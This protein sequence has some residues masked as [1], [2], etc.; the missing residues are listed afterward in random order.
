MLRCDW[1]RVAFTCSLPRITRLLFVYTFITFIRLI[2]RTRLPL[3]RCARSTLHVYY[4]FTL[5]LLRSYHVYVGWFGCVC[6]YVWVYVYVVRWFTLFVYFTVWLPV[7]PHAHVYVAFVDSPPYAF[8]FPFTFA[9]RFY[10]L[11]ALVYSLPAV[12]HLDYT[13]SCY[14]WLL[15][16]SF[17]L[18]C[19]TFALLRLIWLD[20]CLRYV[21]ITAFVCVVVYTPGWLPVYVLRL[22]VAVAHVYTFTGLYGYVCGCPY[23]WL[24]FYWLLAFYRFPVVTL[25][26]TFIYVL[27]VGYV[28]VYVLTHTCGYVYGLLPHTV[29]V[30]VLR[31]HLHVYTILLHT[32]CS[33]R[34]SA[35]VADCCYILCGYARLLFTFR[36]RWLLHL[37]HV[38]T[39]FTTL[40]PRVTGYHTV[41]HAAF[42]AAFYYTVTFLYVASF[43]RLRSFTHTAFYVCAVRL[44]LRV[45]FGYVCGSVTVALR[46]PWFGFAFGLVVHGL[47]SRLPLVTAR[48]VYVYVYGAFAF[49]LVYALPAFGF[50][51]WLR[52]FTFTRL[53]TFAVVVTDVA[54]RLRLLRFTPTRF[55]SWFDPTTAI[56]S[57]FTPVTFTADSLILPVHITPFQ[58]FWICDL[59][60]LP[61]ITFTVWTFP[62]VHV[63]RCL[64]FVCLLRL[65]LRVDRGCYVGWLRSLVAVTTF[66]FT[67]TFVTFITHGYRCVYVW[68]DSVTH[69]AFLRLRFVTFYLF[70]FTFVVTACYTF[71]VG[72][73]LFAFVYRVTPRCYW[74]Y[75]VLTFVTHAIC[76][77]PLLRLRHTLHRCTVGLRLISPHTVYVTVCCCRSFY[78]LHVAVDL[79]HVCDSVGYVC[80][81]RFVTYTFVYV[82]TFTDSRWILR[83]SLRLR[84]P[85]I[86]LILHYVIRYVTPLRLLRSLLLFTISRF[87]FAVTHHPHAFTFVT[88]RSR[89][90]L[91]L[92]IDLH[93]AVTF[94]FTDSTFLRLLLI[95]LPVVTFDLVLR[96]FT[97]RICCLLRCLRTFVVVTFRCVY[98]APFFVLHF[99]FT[100]LP[101]YDFTVRLRLLLLLRYVVYALRWLFVVDFTCR[102]LRCCLLRCVPARYVV[103]VCILR[104]R[105]VYTLV[106]LRYTIA[107]VTLLTDALRCCRSRLHRCVT[108]LILL[109]LGSCIRSVDLRFRSVVCL[110]STFTRHVYVWISLRYVPLRLP[111]TRYGYPLFYGFHALLPVLRFGF[112]THHVHVL[113]LVTR[114]LH[115]FVDSGLLRCHGLLPRLRCPFHFALH[116]V[117]TTFAFTRLLRLP[118]FVWLRLHTLPR[119]R[120]YVCL[121]VWLN[122]LLRLFHVLIP[123]RLPVAR[124]LRSRSFTLLHTFT[125]IAARLLRYPLRPLRLPTFTDFTLFT[126]SLL[127]LHAF[128][129]LHFT[130]TVYWF[131]FD[132]RLRFAV[133]IRSHYPFYTFGFVVYVVDFV[134]V[135]RFRTR[136]VT[137]VVVTFTLTVGD[138]TLRTHALRWFVVRYVRVVVTLPG[139]YVCVAFTF[140]VCYVAVWHVYVTLPR[141]VTLRLHVYYVW[142]FVRSRT[143]TLRYVCTTTFDVYVLH[144]LRLR[145]IC[146][147]RLI[148]RYVTL[149][150]LFD[151]V[152]HRL[153]W[154]FSRL[155]VYVV[156]DFVLLFT[157]PFVPVYVHT[158]TLFLRLFV[159]PD[160][161][162]VA[163]HYTHYT[164]T[165]YVRYTVTDLRSHVWFVYGL[166]VCYVVVVCSVIRYVCYGRC[167]TRSFVCSPFPFTLLRYVG[168]RYTF[169]SHVL[170]LPVTRCTT[171]TFG[172]THHTTFHV[173]GA[174]TRLIYRSRLRSTPPRCLDTLRFTRVYLVV[175]YYVYTCYVVYGYV[176]L[177]LL[178]PLRYVTFTLPRYVTILRYV[179]LPLPVV[180]LRYVT[181]GPFVRL[182]RLFTRLRLVILRYILH[183]LRFVTR[184][185]DL[186]LQ[187]CTLPARLFTT[188]PFTIFVC[189]L[190]LFHVVTR[191][192]VWFTRLRITLP[193]T[194]YTPHVVAFPRFHTRLRLRCHVRWLI[195]LLFRIWFRLRYT[196]AIYPALVGCPV[197]AFTTHYCVHV[198]RCSR[199]FTFGYARSFY[200]FV[201]TTF[202]FTFTWFCRGYYVLRLRFT[203]TFTFTFTV[204]RLRLHTVVFLRLRLRTFVRL[205][206]YRLLRLRLRC[207]AFSCVVR[208]PRCLTHVYGY[209]YCT[210]AVLRSRLPLV[211]HTVCSFTLVPPVVGSGLVGLRCVYTTHARSLPA[212]RLLRF[213][214]PHTFTLPTQLLR[215]CLFITHLPARSFVY[216]YAT[217]T[218]DFAVYVLRLD[219]LRIGSTVARLRTHTAVLRYTDVLDCARLRLHGL[220]T[221]TVTGLVAVLTFTT[222]AVWLRVAF[223]LFAH[224]LHVLRTVYYV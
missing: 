7:C 93:V 75:V 36:S 145:L 168:L 44:I 126:R 208:T 213:N 90:R 114:L 115:R 84:V 24:T 35:A 88:L 221:V 37:I 33:L 63:V 118:R 80:V 122:L 67:F 205:T 224:V 129:L 100:D 174:R 76:C 99:T 192:F 101:R 120:V 219:W 149:V 169:D 86:L 43:V 216:V 34:G 137:R 148:Y 42:V 124:L 171:V 3:P 162:V 85:H 54:L 121:P 147:L 87:P 15:R 40:D 107:F 91:L 55:Y 142:P 203:F 68:S 5:R 95:D 105:C 81:T 210:R 201:Y 173:Y 127:P 190:R 72:R 108:L 175:V 66:T 158:F 209:G 198:T 215:V 143:F 128:A 189:S 191:S 165:L 140:T 132:L 71:Y 74:F 103:Y 32:F 211:T 151:Y 223:T 8:A 220:N 89:L 146:C 119:L 50:Y 14:G 60:V 110:R 102:S 152:T 20:G 46:L 116:H 222:V 38:Y 131:S 214:V 139:Y 159:Y 51:V 64:A 78:T 150:T 178:P 28:C 73:L 6:V 212:T 52:W 176:A 11:F 1:L 161:Y 196:C 157:F 82:V 112:S 188:L 160:V 163:L 144:V 125:L 9:L 19:V 29:Y 65:L 21:W 197:Y 179:P 170:R 199:T 26:S 141:L 83:C 183:R 133:C 111:F 123:L 23:L 195:T 136:L 134:C 79:L 31:L 18:R 156:V 58:P 200:A 77:L 98:V 202:T 2:T 39:T 104:L 217:R 25:R 109:L 154:T 22:H 185:T 207:S 138:F 186:D 97:L 194:R 135:P 92:R 94:T 187:F 70:T 166:I 13:V 177:R 96:W 48:T 167:S 17:T 53:R 153:R 57:G 45:T 59:R 56:R 117:Y 184:Y 155:F 61:F 49:P 10:G 27:L 16:C 218:V 62:F 113:R 172:C 41:A 4:D 30:P 204:C 106:L 47:R 12:T 206:R 193:H 180:A 182:R 164:F 130:F 69:V 181:F